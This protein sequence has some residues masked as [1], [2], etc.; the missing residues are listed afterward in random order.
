MAQQTIPQKCWRNF[1]NKPTSNYEFYISTA[2]AQVEHA[3]LE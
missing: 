3:T 1:I 2:L